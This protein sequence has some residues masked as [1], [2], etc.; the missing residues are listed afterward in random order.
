MQLANTQIDQLHAAMKDLESFKMQKPSDSRKIQSLELE[1]KRQSD[2]LGRYKSDNKKLSKQ[3]KA[4]QHE[5][6]SISEAHE[7]L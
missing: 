7:K 4:L 1:V 5:M 6:T 2:E 3:L